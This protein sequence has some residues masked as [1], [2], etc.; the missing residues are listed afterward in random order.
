MWFFKRTLNL[1]ALMKNL[2]KRLAAT[3]FCL[4]LLPLTG[5]LVFSGGLLPPRF[6]L[7]RRFPLPPCRL[8]FF[9]PPLFPSAAP[10]FS[11][12]RFL[13]PLPPLAVLPFPATLLFPA[14]SVS[15]AL[16][17]SSPLPAPPSLLNGPVPVLPMLLCSPPGL[18]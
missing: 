16:F 2:M 1:C 15:L 11:C 13:L 14:A 17:L 8:R 5:C 4:A 9:L 6:S 3:A 7:C 18:S 10:A 12:R